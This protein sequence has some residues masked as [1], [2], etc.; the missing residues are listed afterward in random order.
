MNKSAPSPSNRLSEENKSNSVNGIINDQDITISLNKD[1]IKHKSKSVEDIR[2]FSLPFKTVLEENKLDSFDAFNNTD[3]G[4]KILIGKENKLNEINEDNEVQRFAAPLEEVLEAS[5]SVES[6]EI[7]S[8][9]KVQDCNMI[10]MLELP[11]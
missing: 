6:S 11:D 8:P 3:Q 9:N 7:D 4:I 2:E 10:D 5:E 1:A